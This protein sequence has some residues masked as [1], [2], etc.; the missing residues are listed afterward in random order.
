M[1]TRPRA[2]R[3]TV[4]LPLALLLAACGDL[5]GPGG[6][7]PVVQLTAPTAG[8]VVSVD[9]VA[10]TGVA[11]DDRMVVRIT[12]QVTQGAEVD[13]PIAMARAVA[14]SG[15]VHGIPVGNF[16]LT[17][18]AYD[19]EGRSGERTVALSRSGL[20]VGAE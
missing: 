20:A 13:V 17:V 15:T 16:S 1:S 4:L 9:S 2:R 7:A 5:N 14:F 8:A 11:S 6:E 19:A 10:I 18:R 12:T 3:T